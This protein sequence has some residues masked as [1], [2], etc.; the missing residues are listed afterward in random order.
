M[1]YT[2]ILV[3]ATRAIEHKHQI[4]KVKSV[5][6]ASY[7]RVSQVRKGGYYS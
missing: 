1:D 3:G 5:P 7:L 4:R 6:I 2:F